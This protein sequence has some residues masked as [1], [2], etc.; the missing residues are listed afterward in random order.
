MIITTVMVMAMTLN[1]TLSCGSCEFVAN[2]PALSY[3]QLCTQRSSFKQT[4]R[5]QAEKQLLVF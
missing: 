3:L 2:V 5:C 1:L 4:K